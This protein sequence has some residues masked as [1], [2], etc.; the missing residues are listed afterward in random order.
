MLPCSHLSKTFS[1]AAGASCSVRASTLNKQHRKAAN[2][3]SWPEKPAC[4]LKHQYENKKN[5]LDGRIIYNKVSM[6]TKSYRVSGWDFKT[7][8]QIH[9]NC[10]VSLFKLL[11]FNCIYM[12][13][14]RIRHECNT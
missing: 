2:A 5:K 3:S 12:Y 11:E 1:A 13:T 4:K 6:L 10:Y 9:G 8:Q 14:I 7:L